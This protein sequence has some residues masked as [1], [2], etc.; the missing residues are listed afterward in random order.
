MAKIGKGFEGPRG[1][2][3]REIPA[4]VELADRVF[5]EGRPHDMSRWFPTLFHPENR[6][7]LRIVLLDG[8]PVSLVAFT[9]RDLWLGGVRLRAAS[10]GS[11][12]TDTQH[13]GR[14]LASVLLLDAVRRAKAC[15]V[16]LFLISGG[17]GLYRRNGCVDAGLYRTLRMAPDQN[18]PRLAVEI[19]PWTVSDLPAMTALHQAEPVRYVRDR[20]EMRT[21]LSTDIL[22]CRPARTWV[23]RSGKETVAYLCAQDPQDDTEERSVRIREMAGSRTAILAA[24]RKLFPAYQVERIEMRCLAGDIETAS[25]AE[26]CGIPSEPRG[27]DGTMKIIDRKGFFAALTD[28]RRERLGPDKDGAL[29]ITAGPTVRFSL[30]GEELAIAKDEDLAAMVFGSR[31]WKTSRIPTTALRRTLGRLFPLPLVDYGLNY[32]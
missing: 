5:G 29:K 7:N 12:A 18:L 8:Q 13:R 24:V 25:I 21:L 1:A 6:D 15:G 9:V 4:I 10:I 30:D 28:Y 23:V 14:G 22:C 3:A 2:A 20:D 32:I 31:E 16:Q 26:E 19:R 11:V 17:R 27:F